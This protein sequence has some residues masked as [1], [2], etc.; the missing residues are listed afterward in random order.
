MRKFA[1][2][3]TSSIWEDGSDNSSGVVDDY[4]HC[5][6]LLCREELDVGEYDETSHQ[7]P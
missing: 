1:K 3:L 5:R 7:A 4:L 6:L 2:E